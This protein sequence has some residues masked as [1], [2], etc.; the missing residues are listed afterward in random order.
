M[1]SN[2]AASFEGKYYRQYC[3]DKSFI[4][5]LLCLWFKYIH[6]W[7]CTRIKIQ[8][9]QYKFCIQNTFPDF[10]WL[11]ISSQCCSSNLCSESKTRRSLS[12]SCLNNLFFLPHLLA[13][14]SPNIQAAFRGEWYQGQNPFLPMCFAA[15]GF[16]GWGGPGA[17]ESHIT[18]APG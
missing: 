16:R 4:S 17:G 13:L 1:Y 5:H 18:E 14:R 3:Y 11:H 2:V 7:G 8:V 10:S 15:R 12:L 6:V 9:F